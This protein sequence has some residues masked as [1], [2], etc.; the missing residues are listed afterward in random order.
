M[1]FINNTLILYSPETRNI[2]SKKEEEENY[3]QTKM[4]VQGTGVF[5]EVC[6]SLVSQTLVSL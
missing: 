6:Q 1:I 3:K 2:F 5:F 4:D